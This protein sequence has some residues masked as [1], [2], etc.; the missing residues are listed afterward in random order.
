M[1]SES[2]GGVQL[3]KTIDRSRHHWSPL[4]SSLYGQVPTVIV[5]VV[6]GPQLLV[7]QTQRR[8]GSSNFRMYE[9][10]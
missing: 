9:T 5:L 3:D 8:W 2:M 10:P 7:A 4:T 6:K 1:G